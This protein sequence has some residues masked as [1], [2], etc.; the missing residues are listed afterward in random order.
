MNSLSFKPFG[1]NAIAVYLGY[2]ISNMSTLQ[3]LK[4]LEKIFSQQ[5]SWRIRKSR[6]RV[7]LED[8]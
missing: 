3:I 5:V 6:H 8:P 4:E 1:L 7:T 2:L